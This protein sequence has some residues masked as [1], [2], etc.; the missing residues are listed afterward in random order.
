MLL[1]IIAFISAAV[2]IVLFVRAM[3]FKSKPLVRSNPRLQEF[4]KQM[5]LAVTIFLVLI[6]CLIFYAIVKL[7]W[8]WL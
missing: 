4:K 3:F 1:K 8:T 6:G 2:P 5:N 7:I